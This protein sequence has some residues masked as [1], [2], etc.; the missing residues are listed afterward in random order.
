[1]PL[2]GTRDLTPL[3][4]GAPRMSSLHP[5]P[6]ETPGAQV[7]HAMYEI[8]DAAIVA[9]LPPA[10]HPTIPPVVTFTVAR[11]PE[12]PVGPFT[13]AQ[14]RVGCRA[15]VRPRGYLLHAVCDSEEA[16]SAL[17][18]GW[19][20]ACTIGAIELHRYHDSIATSVHIDGDEVL[21]LALVDPEPISGGDI[22]YV[23]NMNLARVDDGSGE[24]PW[25]VQVDP[26]YVFHRAER[27][28]PRLDAFDRDAW[29]AAGVD[30]VYPV[31]ASYAVCDTGF[32]LIRYVVD[33]AKPAIAGTRTVG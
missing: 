22:Q 12:S 4:A 2:S 18:S 27:G 23:A 10:L 11:Y 26:D 7:L 6:W 1:M 33:P 29:A 31:V 24:Q 9:L 17:G 16:A 3:V 28:R 13:L 8:D 20:Y 30:P 19:G 21:R 32:P 5:E 25:L 15:G 14:V